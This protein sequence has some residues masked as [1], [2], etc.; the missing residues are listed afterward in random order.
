MHSKIILKNKHMKIL[1]TFLQERKKA[2]QYK[3]KNTTNNDN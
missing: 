1:D 3:K 2:V